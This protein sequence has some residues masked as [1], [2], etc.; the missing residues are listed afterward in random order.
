LKARIK[1]E[2]WHWSCDGGCCDEYG[3][4]L[5]INDS[6]ITDNFWGEIETVTDMLSM[7]GVECEVVYE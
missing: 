4:N 5:Y 6:L 7:F 3:T 1:I 2:N